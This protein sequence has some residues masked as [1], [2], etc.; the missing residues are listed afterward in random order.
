ME[1]TQD[2]LTDKVQNKLEFQENFG[3]NEMTD[4]EAKDNVIE[5]ENIV[6]IENKEK[7]MEA[8]TFGE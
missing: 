5:L 3:E 8:N 2:G 1:V 6:I 4:C 7:D